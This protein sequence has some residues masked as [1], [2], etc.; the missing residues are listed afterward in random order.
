MAVVRCFIC[1]RLAELPH[2][3]RVA[4]DRTDSDE[5][6]LFDVPL[7]LECEERMWPDEDQDEVLAPEE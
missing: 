1:R 7:C 5:I 4:L 3:Q 2:W 6:N